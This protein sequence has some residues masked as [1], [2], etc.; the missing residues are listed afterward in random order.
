MSE[1]RGV[2]EILA[3]IE[4][5]MK[6][7]KESHDIFRA[8]LTKRLDNHG[9]RIGKL[10]GWRTLLTGAWIGAGLVIGGIIKVIAGH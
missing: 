2:R 7:E 10:E 6:A 3:G 1:H 4:A 9:G 8:D 5:T